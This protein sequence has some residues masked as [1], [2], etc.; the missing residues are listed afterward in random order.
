M[1]KILKNLTK[2]DWLTVVLIV[3]LIAFQV[4]LDLKLPDYM[5]E[6]TKLIQTDGSTMNEI[7]KQGGF[8]LL[9]ALGSLGS[10]V[11]VGYLTSRL[12]ANFSFNLRKN[13]F[14]KVSLFGM[15]E[16]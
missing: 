10:A 16:I 8:M 13:V 1:L 7:L 6:I 3:A 9:C 5:S 11:I 15:E 2:R 14:K 4:W 12:S